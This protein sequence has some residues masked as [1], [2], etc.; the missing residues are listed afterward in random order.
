MAVRPV[1]ALLERLPAPLDLDAHLAA[2]N[3]LW[4]HRTRA[5]VESV[6]PRGRDA[7]TLVLR[8]GAG[9]RGH[10]PGQF[11][12]VGVDVDGVRHRRCYS[13]TSPPDRRRIELTVQATSD[14]VVS[15][16]LVQRCPP[17]TVL[18][19]DRAAGD[20]VLPKRLRGARL[21]F[22]TGG[23][24][25]TPVMGM[26]RSMP[27]D[28][29]GADV[30]VLHHVP[31]ADRDLFPA[32]L[33]VMAARPWL[34]TRVV[35]TRPS[36]GPPGAHLDAR[37]LD[38]SCP[39]WRHR[40]AYVCGPESLLDFATGH[41][42]GTGRAHLLHLERFTPPRFLPPAEP[43]RVGALVHF[44]RSGTA[45]PADPARPLLAVAEDAGLRPSHGCRNGVCRTCSTPIESGRAR[46]LRDGRVSGPGEH[47]QI[48]VAAAD[49]DCVLDL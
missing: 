32:E 15:R 48:C 35:H 41:W 45:A 20:F 29:G 23:S 18:H 3:P 33:A 26:L 40:R 13:I 6:R 39:D 34:R 22:V 5:V 14:G 21:L 4:G 37:R 28:G 8:V 38:E 46:D 7:A 42:S 2:V 49:G 19:L 44:A 27:D 9:W 10:A 47:V 43:G 11:V 12:T 36:D 1:A 17:G 16:Y 25:I 24:G 31:D 30:V